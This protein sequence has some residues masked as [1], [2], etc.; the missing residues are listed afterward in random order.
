[1]YRRCSTILKFAFIFFGLWY[2]LSLLFPALNPSRPPTTVKEQPVVEDIKRVESHARFVLIMSLLQTEINKSLDTERARKITHA[3][4]EASERFKLNPFL[5]LG[6][7][8]AESNAR[9]DVVNGKCLGLMQVMPVYWDKALR[10]AGIIE[11][12]EDYFQIRPAVLAGAFVLRHYLNK[13]KG[14]T[15]TCLAFYSGRANKG[16]YK[17]VQHIITLGGI[18]KDDD[19]KVVE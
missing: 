1:M 9:P 7:I 19:G 18:L 10:N 17:K 11:A 15:V 2:T 5:I 8:Y 16:Y 4:L 6:V 3:V 12:K 13:A 14:D